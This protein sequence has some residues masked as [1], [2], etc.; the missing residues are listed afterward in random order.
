MAD[1]H[2]KILW[3]KTS[4]GEEA[5]RR[6]SEA[7]TSGQLSDGKVVQEL[8]LR[9]AEVLRVPYVIAAPS[10]SMALLMSMLALRVGPGDEVIVPNYTWIASAHSAL[11]LGANIVLVDV[12]PDRP[13]M[14]MA[15]VERKIN[16]RTKA[17]IPVHLA[18]RA[19]DVER[20]RGIAA[21]VGAFVVEDACQAI[22]SKAADGRYLGTIGHIGCYSLGVAKLLAAGQGG[23]VA[24]HDA[25]L[26][27]RMRAIKTHGVVANQNDWEDYTGP[28][29]NFK[30]SDILASVV[31][32][33][34]ENPNPRV[35]HVCAIYE[36]YHAGLANLPG[37][38]VSEM[39]VDSGE[40]PLWTEIESP[41]LAEIRDYLAERGVQT[42]RVHPP[43]SQAAHVRYPSV[44]PNTERFCRE[45]LVLPSGPTQPLENVDRVIMLLRQWALSRNNAP[46]RAQ[47]AIV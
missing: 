39:L 35:D 20:L 22:L 29:Y 28:G 19:N 33:Q 46:G 16:A 25:E 27:A 9:A 31:L 21:N 3:W 45:I 37:L 43:L 38:R 47:A 1:A 14:D 30:V 13:V 44:H 42:R 5:P 26:H 11:L 40:V 7:I 18:G 24:T 34:F 4:V 12:L 8:E 17:I 36:R 41:H 23:L 2:N 15:E 10:G 32:P 6:A